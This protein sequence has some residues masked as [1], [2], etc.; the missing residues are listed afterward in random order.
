VKHY[1]IKNFERFQHYKK[2]AGKP[3]WIKL[4]RDLWN[5]REFYGLTDSAKLFFIGLLTVASESTD[6]RISND[7]EWLAHRL[8]LSRRA[9]NFAPLIAAGFLIE[10]GDC[11]GESNDSKDLGQQQSRASLEPAYANSTS[12]KIREEKIR[13]EAESHTALNR[14]PGEKKDPDPASSSSTASSSKGALVLSGEP[15]RTG[16]KPVGNRPGPRRILPADFTLTREMSD[17]AFEHGRRPRALFEDFCD[18]WRS[19]GEVRRDWEAA[20]RL[21]VRRAAERKEH[22]LAPGA[23]RPGGKRKLMAGDRLLRFVADDNGDWKQIAVERP[24]VGSSEGVVV[25]PKG[26]PAHAVSPCPAIDAAFAELA[27]QK[28]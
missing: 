14:I 7:R 19:K 3:A 10:D 21:W 9:I 6:N 23:G 1:R 2:D 5:D 24:Q 26:E 13:E 20:F 27:R 28:G 18:H 4:Y 15:D 16:E 17:Y 12:E 8:G 11:S 25:A 22:R